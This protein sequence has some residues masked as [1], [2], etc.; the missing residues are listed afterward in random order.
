MAASTIFSRLRHGVPSSDLVSPID[1]A[2]GPALGLLLIGGL[3]VIAGF[4]LTPFQLATIEPVRYAGLAAVMLISGMAARR[5]R[6]GPL[7]PILQGFGTLMLSTI[8]GLLATLLLCA[9]ALPS[10][11]RMLA[12]ADRA[13]GFDI[14]LQ[15]ALM[16]AHPRI[17]HAAHYVYFSWIWEP[18]L[19][20]TILSVT[21]QAERCRTF[22]LAWLVA[23]T[24]SVL[25]WPL[26]PSLSTY[27]AYGLHAGQVPGLERIDAWQVAHYVTGIRNGSIR[28]IDQQAAFLGLISF[29]SFHAAGAM[30]IA[31]AMWRTP[32]LWFPFV[33]LNIAVACVA[34]PIGAHYLVDIIAGCSVAALA[35][36]IAKVGLDRLQRP[37]PRKETD[38]AWKT[39][40]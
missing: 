40:G 16:R 25:L 13:L 29:P 37:P 30:L 28:V 14:H 12:G 31:W 21:R 33:L 18:A 36:G 7:G 9:V 2:D 19:A 38:T 27:P 35:I 6:F 15:L 11:D 8:I 22:I 17:V 1:R 20:V 39:Y 23:L 10:A 24:V 3:A 26:F 34:I 32:L 5:Y 4:V